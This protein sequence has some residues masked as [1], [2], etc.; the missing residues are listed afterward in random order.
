MRYIR[1]KL[2]VVVGQRRNEGPKLCNYL[3][4]DCHVTEQDTEL[5]GPDRTNY[6]DNEKL[7][8]ASGILSC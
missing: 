7:T 2:M 3:G 1:E 6:K 4:I 8:R 5:G